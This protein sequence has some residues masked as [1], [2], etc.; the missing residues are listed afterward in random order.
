MEAGNYGVGIPY[1]SQVSFAPNEEHELGNLLI[2]G[3]CLSPPKRKS[4]V[5]RFV[6]VINEN[7]VEKRH[8]IFIRFVC[9]VQQH[10]SVVVAEYIQGSA[11]QDY[12]VSKAVLLIV[13]GG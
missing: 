5:H 12:E 7:D 3:L 11:M 2:V 8:S 9:A 1:V 6:E 10:K 4:E 13:L